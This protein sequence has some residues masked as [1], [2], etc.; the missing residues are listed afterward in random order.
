MA[1]AGCCQSDGARAQEE[2]VIGRNVPGDSQ[3]AD[4]AGKGHAGERPDRVRGPIKL[5]A[6]SVRGWWPILRRVKERLAADNAALVA[7]GVAYYGLLALFPAVVVLVSL[8]GMVA[9]PRD[10]AAQIGDLPALPEAA[11]EIVTAQFE[12]VSASAGTALRAGIVALAISLWSSSRAVNA[13]II[14]MNLVYR[15]H[16]QR[17]FIYR[18]VLAIAFTIVILIAAI[19][20]LSVITVL[21]AL[22]DD[23]GLVGA[24]QIVA[25]GVPWAF[26]CVGFLCVCSVLYRFG[27]DRRHARRT[28]ISPGGV[29]ASLLWIVGSAGFS[30]YVARFARYNEIYGS[31]GA[32]IILLFWFWFSAFVIIL[33]A[34]LNAE[35]EHQTRRDTAVRR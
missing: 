13:L 23:L 20:G 6:T 21:P 35:I 14:T 16:G 15:V 9:D 10:I 11:K 5:F 1:V 25:A 12:R 27:P 24:D 19:V 31:V 4:G 18:N 7:A 22:M 28:W 17:N 33:G 3:T 29:L 26:L 32:V 34:E 30:F 2:D 8:Y